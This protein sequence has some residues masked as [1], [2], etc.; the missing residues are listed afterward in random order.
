MPPSCE[1]VRLT[2][3]SPGKNIDGWEFGGSD[4]LNICITFHVRPS[5]L[6]DRTT[7]RIAFDLPR[8]QKPRTLEPQ[9]E[10]ADAGEQGTDRHQNNDNGAAGTSTGRSAF[11]GSTRMFTCGGSVVPV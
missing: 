11:A 9:I 8:H 7:E 2:G 1:G 6:E 5:L 3:K 4:G 10:S